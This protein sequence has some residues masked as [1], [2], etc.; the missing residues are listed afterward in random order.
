MAPGTFPGLGSLSSEASVNWWKAAR[1]SGRRP[2]KRP[3]AGPMTT[4]PK[5]T[6]GAT[7]TIS[8]SRMS[9]GFA[10]SIS[11]GP[12]SGCTFPR[13]SVRTPSGLSVLAAVP[14]SSASRHKN[15]TASPSRT[16]ATAGI[17]WFHRLW[18]TF[19]KPS[20]VLPPPAGGFAASATT[21]SGRP[22]PG[23]VTPSPAA[24]SLE[25]M[26]ATAAA[27]AAPSE[28]CSMNVRRETALS[29]W[30]K[31]TAHLPTGCGRATPTPTHPGLSRAVPA[32]RGRC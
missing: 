27:A 17:S 1:T 16:F 31:H 32:R 21:M 9:P 19:E 14:I 24:A 2:P 20:M 11:T 22:T 8:T 4:Y 10:P 28:N 25:P 3:R 7:S 26:P 18:R 5:S 15:W 13:S 6:S 29:E 30:M 23:A 12:V